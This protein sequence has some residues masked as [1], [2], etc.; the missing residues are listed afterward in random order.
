[1]DRRHIVEIL[2]GESTSSNDCVVYRFCDNKHCPRCLEK[3]GEEQSKN[4]AICIAPDAYFQL[5]PHPRPF[6]SIDFPDEDIR[7]QFDKF[8]YFYSDSPLPENSCRS[9][10]SGNRDLSNTFRAG[11]F[12]VSKQSGIFEKDFSF[13]F[14]PIIPQDGDS[15]LKRAKILQHAIG[16]CHA[17]GIVCPRICIMTCASQAMATD[18]VGAWKVAREAEMLLNWL[19]ENYSIEGNDVKSKSN[20]AISI[21]AM[22][23]DSSSSANLLSFDFHRVLEPGDVDILIPFDGASGNVLAKMWSLSTASIQLYSIPWFIIPTKTITPNSP[24]HKCF[25]LPYGEGGGRSV[26][27]K[28]DAFARAKGWYAL[29]AKMAIESNGNPDGISSNTNISPSIGNKL[30]YEKD[31]AVNTAL[32]ALQEEVVRTLIALSGKG[33]EL[34]AKDTYHIYVLQFAET[35]HY[36]PFRLMWRELEDT[37]ITY[38]GSREANREKSNRK[39]AKVKICIVTN[40]GFARDILLDATIDENVRERIQK[41]DTSIISDRIISEWT[42]EFADAGLLALGISEL[43]ESGM[44]ELGDKVKG[45]R[46]SFKAET[47]Y[48]SRPLIIRLPIWGIALSNSKFLNKLARSDNNSTRAFFWREFGSKS[49]LM[50]KDSF[51]EKRISIYGDETTVTR[52]FKKNASTSSY[53]AQ[54]LGIF[55]SYVNWENEFDDLLNGAVD[56]SITLRPWVAIQQAASNSIDVSV[57]YNHLERPEAFTNLY[58]SK[59]YLDKTFISESRSIDSHWSRIVEALL[60]GLEVLAQH[61]IANLYEGEPASVTASESQHSTLWAKYGATYCKYYEILK[62]EYSDK[63]API[64]HTIHYEKGSHGS[65]EEIRKCKVCETNLFALDILND[66]RIYNLELDLLTENEILNAQREITASVKNYDDL[67]SSQFCA[68]WFEKNPLYTRDDCNTINK[69]W[70]HTDIDGAMNFD[71]ICHDG[72]C[73]GNS[74]KDSGCLISHGNRME[75][76]RTKLDSYN[77]GEKKVY[78]AH[79]LEHF[80]GDSEADKLNLM[81]SEFSKYR[82][83]E[84]SSESGG[85]ESRPILSHLRR[86][87]YECDSVDFKDLTDLDLQGHVILKNIWIPPNL[88]G[89]HSHILSNTKYRRSEEKLNF[90][91][92]WSQLYSRYYVL[93]IF[94]YI[95]EDEESCCCLYHDEYLSGYKSALT[96][97]KAVCCYSAHISSA[98]DSHSGLPLLRNLQESIY[99]DELEACRNGEYVVLEFNGIEVAKVLFRQNARLHLI[100]VSYEAGETSNLPRPFSSRNKGDAS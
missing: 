72:V 92:W 48:Y 97:P 58:L 20:R 95:F 11:I 29:R 57:V 34:S 45:S 37:E 5:S 44:D 36:L 64:P 9:E 77:S 7:K 25:Y 90:V 8:D 94:D 86:Y 83:H 85:E 23:G 49:S 46:E 89:N 47:Q 18:S 43:I 53:T 19:K 40:L 66:S 87:G 82:L 13:L 12:K 2:E 4:K 96:D 3:C 31:G 24:M 65:Y 99:F 84:Y 69:L 22:D 70:S 80:S 76:C 21:V 100:G 50:T 74:R 55:F 41:K 60:D 67:H 38:W 14:L 75:K 10:F 54:D 6:V 42:R 62:S 39:E 30:R 98:C 27:S 61:K 33:P 91:V 28:H 73:A 52:L 17:I 16:F 71:S 26:I 35:I 68:R 51:S 63:N 93:Y 78:L 59:K 79:F 1:M 81:F 15:L 56:V 32:R 88:F